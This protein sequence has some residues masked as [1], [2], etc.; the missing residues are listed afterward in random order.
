MLHRPGDLATQ[1]CEFTFIIF[2]VVRRCSPLG[3]ALLCC[4]D[5][6][7]AWAASTETAIVA[8]NEFCKL[9]ACV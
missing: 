5:T 4:C 9:R 8:T 3:S 7:A 6:V 2:V 1:V